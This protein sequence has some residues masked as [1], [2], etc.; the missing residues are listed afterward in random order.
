MITI[1]QIIVLIGMIGVI[2]Y[3]IAPNKVKRRMSKQ[4]REHNR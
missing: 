1:L 2:I 3:A 4:S